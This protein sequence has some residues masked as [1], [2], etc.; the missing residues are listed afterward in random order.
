MPPMVPDDRGSQTSRLS[1]PDVFYDAPRNSS[2]HFQRPDPISAPSLEPTSTISVSILTASQPTPKSN[3][4]VA[5]PAK[6][7]TQLQKSALVFPPIEDQRDDTD[8]ES[9]IDNEVE[10]DD[11]PQILSARHPKV[12]HQ[13]QIAKTRTRLQPRDSEINVPSKIAVY[14]KSRAKSH[15]PPLPLCSEREAVQ[16]LLAELHTRKYN[17]GT[18]SPSRS[19]DSEEEGFLEFDL[20]DFSIYLPDNKYHA[21]ELRGLQ[22]LA[23]RIGHSSFLFDGILSV[24]DERRYV[25]AVPFQI[26]SIGNYG[27]DLH[28]VGSDIWLQSNMNAKSKSN[29]YYRLKTPSPEYKRYHGDFIWL[30]NLAKHFVDYCEASERT[31]CLQDFRSDFSNW[32]KRHH[33]HSPSFRSWYEEYDNDDFR[34]QVAA[35][36]SFLFKE[37]TGVDEKLRSELIFKEVLERDSIP[38][39]KVEE[40]KTIVTPFVYECFKHLR[41]GHHLKVI[42]ISTAPRTQQK[43][44]GKSLDLTVDDNFKASVEISSSIPGS[45]MKTRSL[46]T[47][48]ATKRERMIKS[49]KAG[50]VLSVTKDGEESVWKD[51]GG[52]WK[53]ADDCWYVY[54]QAV[55]DLPDGTRAFDALWLYRPSDTSCAKMK[56]PFQN[57]LFLS[58][59]CT[60]PQKQ[61]KEEEVLDIVKVVWHGHPSE[62]DRRLFIRQT[63]LE[64][65]RFVTLKETHKTCEHLRKAE[66][67]E[68]SSTD[69]KYH[70]GQTVLAIVPHKSKYGLES[71]EIVNLSS[72]GSKEVALLRHL[73]RRQLV[74]GKGRPNELVYTEKL[75][76]V[77]ASKIDGTCLVRFYKESD[78]VQRVIPAPYNRDGIGNAFYISTRTVGVGDVDVLKP[79]EDDMPA[80]LIQGFDPLQV[81]VQLRGMDLYCGGGNFGR[82]LEEG[83]AVHNEWA[84]DINQNAIH[85]Y[86]ANLRDPQRTKLYYGSV[87]DMLSQAM[88]GNPKDSK[89]IPAPGEVDFISAGSPCQGFSTMN[90]SRNNDQGLLNQSLVA[91]VAAYIDFYRPKYG[92]LENVLTMAQKGRGRDEDVLSQLICAIVGLG[93]QLQL[94]VLDSWSCG[95]PQSRSRLFVSFAAPG[96]ELLEHPKLSHSHPPKKDTDRGLGKM[97]NGESFGKRIRGLTPFEFVS[98]GTALAD[99]PDI[100]DGSTYQ[101]IKFPE[102][103]MPVALTTNQ[104]RQIAAIPT[105]PRGM[106]F[107]TAWAWGKGVMTP[108]QVACFPLYRGNGELRETCSKGSKAFGRTNPR[109]LMTTILV[110]CKVGDSRA[111]RVMHWD[112]D[113]T[114]TTM[115]AKRAQGFPDDEILLGNA[116]EG[117]KILGNSVARGVALSIGLALREAWLKNPQ[118]THAIPVSPTVDIP[119]DSPVG[120]TSRERRKLSPLSPTRARRSKHVPDTEDEESAPSRA[121]LTSRTLSAEVSDSEGSSRHPIAPS[122]ARR[123]VDLHFPRLAA[124]MQA[125]LQPGSSSMASLSN[126][127]PAPGFRIVD[128]RNAGRSR[129]IPDSESSADEGCPAESMVH[130]LATYVALRDRRDQTPNNHGFGSEAKDPG[131]AQSLKRPL[132]LLLEESPTG[133]GGKLPRL[134]SPSRLMTLFQPIQYQP[135]GNRALDAGA[136]ADRLHSLEQQNK[137]PQS[138]ARFAHREQVVDDSSDSDDDV[139]FIPASSFNARVSTNASAARN[140]GN[141]AQRRQKVPNARLKSKAN[142]KSAP[143]NQVFINL[144]SDD[145][146]DEAPNQPEQRQKEVVAVKEMVPK[147]TYPLSSAQPYVP[148]DNG[149]M[150]AYARTNQYMKY[151]V[152]RRHGP[153]ST[154]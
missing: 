1:S 14:P 58:D 128:S 50:F 137:A 2:T 53:Q 5:I 26:C 139:K 147:H 135:P 109:S 61:I 150:D 24:G 126:N 124:E 152:N 8:T 127:S 25:S 125:R 12:R 51:E 57:E 52:Q 103:V 13:T 3:I 23:T 54:V 27:E 119:M 44:E 100:G 115:E 142:T 138:Q 45:T 42:D 146:D 91:S 32:M 131:S 122:K 154:W 117:W 153:K 106:N 133:R 46:P 7:L 95:M 10:S 75:D 29:V 47:N 79:I 60:C 123:S 63:Y 120:A 68:T 70:I 101:C 62:R 64:N 85:T 143:K 121:D 110:S 31:I 98:A 16:E 132:D 18:Q 140:N 144:V 17:D 151:D 72:D 74:D 55:H 87:N 97:A 65:E 81:P 134:E 35:N 118:H 130:Q 77:S 105:H 43:S 56:Y 59:N 76:E 36:I 33:K 41:F 102:H 22:H 145:E 9:S 21:F 73:Q 94:F 37:T 84:V 34:R 30:A 136:L 83:G 149:V 82:G 48:T 141:Q 69:H 113:R 148:V 116:Q 80:S 88:R 20:A 66:G 86:A 111:G 39:Q 6:S 49:I 28:E 114:F 71:Y 104:K 108:E 89:L 78:I 93:Y 38:M 107:M 15:I 67:K 4:I 19:S 90:A 129:E 112:Q 40:Q 99:L 96:F 11:E 92:V